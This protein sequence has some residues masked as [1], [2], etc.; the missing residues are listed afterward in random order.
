MKRF[1]TALI[2]VCFFILTVGVT[3][4]SAADTANPADQAVEGS[5]K[6]KPVSTFA[7][8]TNFNEAGIDLYYKAAFGAA[9][10]EFNKQLEYNPEDVA[11][12]V[13]RGIS[14]A[15]RGEYKIAIE[16]LFNALNIKNNNVTILKYIAAV[17]YLD[18]QYQKSVDIYE[19]ATTLSNN[20][21][22]AI[23]GKGCAFMALEKYEE[24]V[25]EF[26][27]V[28]YVAPDD[29]RSFIG[30]GISS[31]ATGK[32]KAAIADLGKAASLSSDDPFI[33]LVRAEANAGNAGFSSA[34]SDLN[35]A[36]SLNYTP[37]CVAMKRAKTEIAASVGSFVLQYSRKGPDEELYET[38]RKKLEKFY[39][40]KR[41]SEI[42]KYFFR[43]LK[44]LMN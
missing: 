35:R 9:I 3:Q 33:Y 22:D 36:C 15:R 41:S 11:A 6:A 7:G 1:W 19:K 20:D 21:Y 32:F 31:N 44:P 26:T 10:L 29:S 28:L 24:A 12:L 8:T 5:A 37:V 16:N 34:V 42:R 4:I 38:A 23:A 14:F 27:R 43:Q 13:N 30:R 2:L 17:Y 39:E 40:A 25:S 18:R